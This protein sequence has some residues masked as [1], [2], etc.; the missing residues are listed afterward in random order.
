M[1]S[2]LSW[3]DTAASTIGRLF[4]PISPPLPAHL[5]LTSIPFAKRKSLAGFLAA[6]ITGCGIGLMYW[7]AGE[8]KRQDGG[9]GELW[10]G[11]VDLSVWMGGKMAGWTFL[12][13]TSW[14][15]WATALVLGVSG[16]IVEALG[17]SSPRQIARSSS[18]DMLLDRPRV[19]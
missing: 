10:G 15:R 16:A 19:G 4:S 18:A 14:G 1:A 13:A 9:W 2:R 5:P 17:E 8:G 12:R 3:S 6:V 11:D 7:H